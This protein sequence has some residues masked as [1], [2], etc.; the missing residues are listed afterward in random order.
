MTRL[1]FLYWPIC[2]LKW[3]FIEQ[4]DCWTSCENYCFLPKTS[5]FFIFYVDAEVVYHFYSIWTRYFIANGY[6]AVYIHIH[7]FCIGLLNPHIIC[8]YT[9][10]QIIFFR[11]IIFAFSVHRFICKWSKIWENRNQFEDTSKYLQNHR[12][13]RSTTDFLHAKPVI[14]ENIIN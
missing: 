1:L 2:V 4:F 14:T 13:A 6:I 5:I 3:G 9:L 8:I 11:Y 7:V 10:I 12:C